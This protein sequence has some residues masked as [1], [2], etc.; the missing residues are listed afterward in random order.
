[1]D[2]HC[3]KCGRPLIQGIS[4]EEAVRRAVKAR[5]YINE[6]GVFRDD[7]ELIGVSAG[8]YGLWTAR[9]LNSSDGVFER[10]LNIVQI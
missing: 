7:V 2:K 5:E 10:Q 1:M 3:N 9:F 6:T 8:A 4:F